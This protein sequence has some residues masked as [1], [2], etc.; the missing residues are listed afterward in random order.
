MRDGCPK[1][2]IVGGYGKMGQIR[3]EALHSL[4]PLT[5]TG[6]HIS[7]VDAPNHSLWTFADVLAYA[8]EVDGVMIC[9]PNN[10]NED[11][12]VR[13]LQAGKHVF[14]EKPP[15]F[16]AGGVGRVAMVLSQHPEAKLMY[17]FNLRHHASIRHMK[18]L[19]DSGELGEVL[20]MRGRYGKSVD[21]DFFNT[22]RADK[23]QAGGGI[24]I[25]QGIHMLDLFLHLG[26][27]FDEV[28][29]FVSNLY[30]KCD[31]EDN[32]FVILRNSKTGRVASMHSTMTQ[33][34]HLFSLEVFLSKGYM[35]LDGLKTPS[36]MYGDEVLSVCRSRTE[37][38]AAAWNTETR[39]TFKSDD[40]WRSEVQHWTDA[41]RNDTPITIGTVDDAHAVMEVI[42]EIYRQKN[43]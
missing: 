22:W 1:I 13:A 18:G 11:Y 20:W 17:G 43:S 29:A 40:S 32:A 4:Y 26:G 23:T 38:P 28:R 27:T 19:I 10:F 25:D 41:I 36:G 12:T 21:E 15:A 8:H 6:F 42:D 2:A 37:P 16:T 7:I 33:W 34:R 3:K 30:W 9:T 5:K 14:C 24:L 39:T 35:V 31:V